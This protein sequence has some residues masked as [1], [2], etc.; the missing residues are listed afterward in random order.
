MIESPATISTRLALQSR[1][2]SVDGVPALGAVLVTGICGRLGK[3]LARV[4][5]RERR[6]VGVDRRPF[7]DKPK[8]S[9]SAARS[10]KTSFG[11]AISKRSSTWG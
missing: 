7:L 2:P 6:V 3:H 10:S 4:L 9:T 5:H 8:E 1:A 11:A